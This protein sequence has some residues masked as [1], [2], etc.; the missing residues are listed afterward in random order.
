MIRFS[1]IIKNKEGV[2]ARPAGEIMKKAA[3]FQCSCELFANGQTISLKGG[4]FSMMGLGLK[5]GD[6]MDFTFKGADEK[7]A[8]EAVKALVEKLL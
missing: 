1:Y 3:E 7:E 8:C 4:I 6:E 2:H 5:T